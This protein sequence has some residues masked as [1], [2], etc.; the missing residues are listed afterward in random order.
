LSRR[1]PISDID[2]FV[3]LVLVDP[4]DSFRFAI[5]PLRCH[6]L[7]GGEQRRREF[8]GLIGGRVYIVQRGIPPEK[9]G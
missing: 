9:V 5:P 3:N 6:P 2:Q 8:V 4:L 7:N 1:T